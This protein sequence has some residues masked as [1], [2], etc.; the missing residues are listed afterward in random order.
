MRKGGIY[1]KPKKTGLTQLVSLICLNRAMTR[2]QKAI[3]MMSITEDL[4][5]KTIFNLIRYA[6]G[7]VPAIIMPSRSKQNEGEIVFGPPDA[8]RNPLR[9]KKATVLDDYLNTWLTTV[10]T[11][12]DA[13]DSITNYIAFTDEFPKIKEN[14]YPDELLEATR[15]TVIEG[16]KRKGTIFW[17]SY[18]PEK[19]DRSFYESRQIYKD[20]KLKTRK[21]DNATGEP[22]GDTK[23][24]LIAH[25]LT[26]QEGMFNC[27]DIYGK[28]IHKKVMDAIRKEKED[29]NGDAIKIQAINRQYP[30]SESDPWKETGREETPF[31]NLRLSA[32]AELLE[33]LHSVSAFPYQDFNLDFEK[34]PV[35]K[36]DSELYT[37]EG[38]IRLKF[39]SEDDKMNGAADGRFKWFHPE[40][41]PAWFLEKHLN[42]VRKDPKTGLLMPN[43]DA[44]FFISIDPTKYRISKN[45]G[46]GSNNSIQVFVLP[47][48]EVNAEIGKNVTN[49]R[50]MCSYLYRHNKPSDTFND[51]IACILLF[52]CMVQIESNVSTWVTKLIE[53]GL[54]NFVLMVNEFGALEPFNEFKKQKYFT[55]NKDEID[56]YFQAGAEFLGEPVGPGEIDNIDYLDD[57]DVI[58]QLMMIRKDNTTD[59]DAAVA[60]LEGQMGIDGWLGWKRANE[61]IKAPPS[62]QMRQFAISMLN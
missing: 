11:R 29:A 27:C 12:R 26:A 30:M 45:T 4:A 61:K 19:T 49:R 17:L 9:K 28:A 8:S 53:M 3:R 50:L 39:I 56:Q 6:V 18:V 37:F 44:P 21:T 62:E 52:G 23:S 41:T 38:R 5:K 42:K 15:P 13:F 14:T 48:A 24:K 46:K 2:K 40:W 31:D 25:T 47:N 57:I 60:F 43:A 36:T 59:Y 10:P 16:F 54:G 55:S 20:S 51:M 58:T 7:K 1:V 33:E 34:M 35:K 32:K 22:Y